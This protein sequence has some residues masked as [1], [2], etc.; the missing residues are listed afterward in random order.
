MKRRNRI[1]AVLLA[2]VLLLGGFSSA[3]GAKVTDNAKKWEDAVFPSWFSYPGDALNVLNQNYQVSTRFYTDI[4]GDVKG[5]VLSEFYEIPGG[6][7]LCYG[8]SF[9]NACLLSG[10]PAASSFTSPEGAAYDDVNDLPLGGVSEELRLSLL[11][12]IKYCYVMQASSS[13]PAT[14]EKHR[15]DVAGLRAAV[16]DFVYNDG[17]AVAVGLVGKP[18]HEVLAVGLLGDEDIVILDSNDPEQL[19]VMDFTG[20]EW[21][22]TCAGFIWRSGSSDFDF[23]TNASAVYRMIMGSA[24]DRDYSAEDYAY[25]AAEE[26]TGE[27]DIYVTAMERMDED[28]LLLLYDRKLSCQPEKNLL[29]LGAGYSQQF[30]DDTFCNYSWLAADTAVALRNTDVWTHAVGAFGNRT[31]MLCDVPAGGAA[32]VM[33]EEGEPTLLLAAG[34]G[35]PFRFVSL[36]PD[37]TGELARCAIEGKVSDGEAFVARKDDGL[38][39]DG[40]SNAVVRLQADGAAPVSCGGDAFRVS[41]SA[42]GT[43][44]EVTVKGDADDDG[45]LTSADARLVLRLSVGLEQRERFTLYACDYDED[46]KTTSA[47][48]RQILRSSVGLKDD[49]S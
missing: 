40:V 29:S 44:V 21:S 45:K 24:E 14:F 8:I 12:F 10:L 7:G 32:A 25:T 49:I 35:H 43:A 22:Y 31:G 33:A 3:A 6:H 41:V 9:A 2:A 28:K 34:S 15:N 4:F 20:S 18:S 42:D 47:D 48:A 13:L 23:D 39:V 38:R 26:A 37:G 27:T 19:Y 46:G 1:A 36:A 11:S 17:P 5:A 16:A 30:G